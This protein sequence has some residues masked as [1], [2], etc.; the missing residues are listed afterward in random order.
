M[1]SKGYCKNNKVEYHFGDASNCVPVE[2]TPVD[3]F[4]TEEHL[5]DDG[6]KSVSYHDPIRMLFNQERLEKLGPAAIQK[7][8]E[9]LS[10]GK[11]SP[12]NQ[13]RSQC[14]DAT[15]MQLIKSRHI[16]SMSELQAYAKHCESNL[17][18]FK[19]EVTRFIAEQQAKEAEVQSQTNVETNKTE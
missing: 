15:L 6:S 9:T 12:L 18:D 16:Q 5:E 14:D 10:V 13:L 4:Y 19:S 11:S 3:V 2:R 7:W 17:T 8:I 1:I